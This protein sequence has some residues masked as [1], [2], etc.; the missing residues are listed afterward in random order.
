LDFD[1]AT[2]RKPRPTTSRS[3]GSGTTQQLKRFCGGKLK[4]VTQNLGYIRDLGCTSLWLSPVFENNDAP[5]P[6]SEK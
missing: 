2:G 4:G 6:S 1:D 3:Q 5:D